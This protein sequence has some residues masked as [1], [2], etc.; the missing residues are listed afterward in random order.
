MQGNRALLRGLHAFEA[1]QFIY[2]SSMLVHALCR[3]GERIDETQP[4]AL[5]WM[6]PKSKARAEEVLCQEHGEIPYVNLRLA[7]VYDTTSM[8]PTL[9]RQMAR[10]YERDFQS[11]FHSGSPMDWEAMH[12]LKDELPAMVQ[13][14]KNNPL[15]KYAR[16]GVALPE[17]LEEAHREGENAETLRSKREVQVRTEHNA[18]RWAHFVNMGLATWLITQPLLINVQEPGLRTTEM[19]LGLALLVSLPAALSWQATWARWASAGVGT[20]VMAIPFVFNTNSAAA[21]LSD[22]LVGA[23]IFGLAVCLKPEPSASALAS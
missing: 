23:L 2:A 5:G 1:K 20:L 7:G 12:R 4:I 9:A 13:A 16:H 10:I 22:T 11:Y 17:S 3:P 18:N 8:V 19:V 15:R 21:D 6:Y 14:L